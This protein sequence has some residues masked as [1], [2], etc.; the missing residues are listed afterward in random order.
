MSPRCSRD[1]WK[2]K[3]ERKRERREDSSSEEKIRGNELPIRPREP[4]EKPREKIGWAGLG[5]EVE[6]EKNLWRA[7]ERERERRVK[8]AERRTH[9]MPLRNGGQG[10]E[11][12]SAGWFIPLFHS[13]FLPLFFFFF[14][15]DDTTTLEPSPLFTDPAETEL[16][17]ILR[18][19]YQIDFIQNCKYILRGRAIDRKS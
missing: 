8:S 19:I 18:D 15:I 1:R 4:L 3:R 9:A 11:N 2:T 14:S 13:F 7:Q 6:E 5:G 10:I 12:R 16:K 17:K